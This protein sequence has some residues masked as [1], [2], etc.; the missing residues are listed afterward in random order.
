MSSPYSRSLGPV[1]PMAWPTPAPSPAG[2]LPVSLSKQVTL[3]PPP[4]PRSRSS[5][6]HEPTRHRSPLSSPL[7]PS[8]TWKE[9]DVVTLVCE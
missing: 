2:G 9:G 5:V 3:H 4:E 1:D 6:S 8:D 7:S